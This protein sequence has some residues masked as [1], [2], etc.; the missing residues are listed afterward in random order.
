MPI[1]LEHWIHA[2]RNKIFGFIKYAAELEHFINVLLSA[3]FAE[4][5][6]GIL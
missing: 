2:I 3:I 5:L 4:D 6:N 1:K